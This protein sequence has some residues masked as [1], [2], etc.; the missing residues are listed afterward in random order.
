MIWFAWSGRASSAGDGTQSFLHIRQV[1]Y[2]VTSPV[3]NLGSKLHSYVNSLRC[4]GK[5]VRSNIFPLI[6][7]DLSFFL[8]YL[9][10]SMTIL[11][12][13]M[14]VCMCIMSMNL[15]RISKEAV[16]RG[17]GS[18]GTEVRGGYNLPCGFW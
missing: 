9:F 7:E 5:L 14:Y 17:V 10:M 16:R 6:P 3:L 12:V 2:Q 11:P 8:L 15:S 1:S 18:P 13:G 4:R